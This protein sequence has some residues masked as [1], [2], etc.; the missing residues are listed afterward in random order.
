[1]NEQADW[2]A[3]LGWALVLIGGLLV[4]AGYIG[5]SGKETEALQ[6]PYLASG[7]IGGLAVVAFGSALLIA[8]DVRRDRQRL[9]QIEGEMLELQD[10][11]RS[12]KSEAPVR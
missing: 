6:L 9:G 10:L 5:V 8:A 7:S 2:R 3:R 12:L 1:M 11:V 4:V